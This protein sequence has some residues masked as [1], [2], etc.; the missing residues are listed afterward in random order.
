VLQ[1]RMSNGSHAVTG[2]IA[3]TVLAMAIG[4]YV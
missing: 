2:L 3:I 4:R 1:K